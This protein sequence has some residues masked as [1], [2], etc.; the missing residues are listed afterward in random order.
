MER[1]YGTVHA[2]F[3]AK[4]P[5]ESQGGIDKIIFLQL[6]E[7]WHLTLRP[8]EAPAGPGLLGE[9]SCWPQPRGSGTST[10]LL[11]TRKAG[12]TR[13]LK[14][15]LTTC[16]VFQWMDFYCYP[17]ASLASEWQNVVMFALASATATDF[18]FFFL[19][20]FVALHIGPGAPGH[21][22]NMGKKVLWETAA[23]EMSYNHL[24]PLHMMDLQ[25]F[26]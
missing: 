17:R 22:V 15:F 20:W 21:F 2:D 12:H 26:A 5:A 4:F 16:Q 9:I 18:L 25:T 8:V 1:H 19:P 3:S 13:S 23:K 24:F 7:R 6:R 11:Q 10:V 14:D